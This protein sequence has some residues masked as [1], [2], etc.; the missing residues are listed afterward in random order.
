MTKYRDCDNRAYAHE[1][2]VCE[3]IYGNFHSQWKNMEKLSGMKNVQVVWLI[4]CVCFDS[5][6]RKCCLFVLC[7]N[8]ACIRLTECLHLLL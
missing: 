2:V 6:D 1:T 5:D 7:P 3:Q 4:V 8:Y